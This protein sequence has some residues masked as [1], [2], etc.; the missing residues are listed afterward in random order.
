MLE[1]NSETNVIY[2]HKPKKKKGHVLWNTSH[3]SHVMT[4]CHGGG[5]LA[6]KIPEECKRMNDNNQV[7]EMRTSYNRRTFLQGELYYKSLY[8]AKGQ[9][10][11]FHSS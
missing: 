1:Y 7:L 8:N 11:S 4:A 10:F 5:C 6:Y 9:F 2:T 3:D